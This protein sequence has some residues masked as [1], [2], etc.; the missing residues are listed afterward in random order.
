MLSETDQQVGKITK[1]RKYNYQLNFTQALNRMKNSIVLLFIRPRQKIKEYI[2]HLENLFISN[3]GLIRPGR[4][5]ERKFRKSKRIY[6]AP[7]KN[8]F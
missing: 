2:V 8:S 1:K 3:L 7:Y 5:I 4:Y 6:P